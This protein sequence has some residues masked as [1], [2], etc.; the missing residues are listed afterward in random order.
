MLYTF[1]TAG[2]E[3]I[4]VQRSL[5]QCE[6]NRSYYR[7]WKPLQQSCALENLTYDGGCLET[8]PTMGE[9]ARGACLLL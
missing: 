7:G 5:L 1:R 9:T 3:E 2:A 6:R 8:T 4:A